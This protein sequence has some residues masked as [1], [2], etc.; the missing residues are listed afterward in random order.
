MRAHKEVDLAPHPVVGLVL[1][2]EVR[3]SFPRLGFETLGPFLRGSKRGPRF[4]AVEEYGGLTRD[5]YNLNL[6][7]S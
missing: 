2:V 4:T 7:R 3:R 6:P 1:Q 5:L